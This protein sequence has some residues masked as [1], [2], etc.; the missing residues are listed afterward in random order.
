[1]DAMTPLSAAAAAARTRTSETEREAVRAILAAD[2]IA[3]CDE[4]AAAIGRDDATARRHVRAITGGG[5]RITRTRN[6][7]I[8]IGVARAPPV[9]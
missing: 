1:M 2:P 7:K 9:L 5:R 4:I 6:E 8:V 3:R